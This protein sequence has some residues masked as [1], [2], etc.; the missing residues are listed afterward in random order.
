MNNKYFVKIHFIFIVLKDEKNLKE[1]RIKSK[2]Q[3]FFFLS[4][5]II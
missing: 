1:I 5:E 2:I 3:I 4:L